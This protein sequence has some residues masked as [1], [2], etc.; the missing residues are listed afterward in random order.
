M[1][2][3][4]KALTDP[5]FPFLRCA[6]IAGVLASIPLGI[7]GSYEPGIDL[8]E[9]EG[10]D[11]GLGAILTGDEQ[12]DGEQGGPQAGTLTDGLEGADLLAVL[13]GWSL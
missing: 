11:G 13:P 7:I 8:V 12:V 9:P 6:L 3:L 1:T 10:V 4:L 5:D 2:E